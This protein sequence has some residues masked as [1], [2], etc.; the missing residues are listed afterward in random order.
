VQ[1]DKQKNKNGIS[2]KTRLLSFGTESGATL[3]Q[4]W[5]F[6]LAMQNTNPG[7]SI[8][9]VKHSNCLIISDTLQL[10]GYKPQ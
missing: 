5:V 3:I 8:L 9:E 7:N 6:S 2:N 4:T 1:L 10:Q